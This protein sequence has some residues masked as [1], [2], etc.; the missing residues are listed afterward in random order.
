MTSSIVINVVG[1]PAPQGSKRHVGKGRMIESSKKVA[2]WREAV[3]SAAAAEMDW[4]ALRL[5]GPLVLEVSF[6]L[7]RPKK[8]K[9]AYPDRMPDLS[10]LIRATEDALTDAG[11]W[12]DDARVVSIDASKFYCDA[13]QQTGA[14][15]VVSKLE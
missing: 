3:K 15:I 7:S 14:R 2:P 12:A 4:S 9:A 13:N 8:P 1:V 10:K 5:D 11:V 6:Y